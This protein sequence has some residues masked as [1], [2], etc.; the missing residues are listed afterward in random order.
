MIKK[1]VKLGTYVTP[2]PNLVV[3]CRGNNGENNA[4][5]VAY[6]CNCSY[7]PPM[8]MVGIVPSRHSYHLI[9]E[10]GCFIINLPSKDFEEEYNYLGS[11]SGRDEDKFAKM[12]IKF[13][14]GKQVN[15]PVLTGCPVNIECEIVDSIM[16]GS[17]E[18]FV[19]KVVH[20]HADEKYVNS[21]GE[22]DFSLIDML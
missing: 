13:E 21:K 20:I 11:H 4:L 15:A 10:S 8:A 9:K 17:H 6:G 16:C 12:N 22:I 3:S 7:A 19:G 1:E 5:V 18:M 14:D 2:K